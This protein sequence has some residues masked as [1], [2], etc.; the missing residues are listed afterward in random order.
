MEAARALPAVIGVLAL[1][2]MW[3]LGRE[4][5]GERAALVATLLLAVS[6]IHVWYSQEVRAY[7]LVFLLVIVTLWRYAVARRTEHM[8]GPMSRY[9]SERWTLRAVSRAETVES[10]QQSNLHPRK[11]CLERSS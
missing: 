9:L 1:P 7:G 4:V 11:A 5:A 6:P 8:A 10:P 3:L 2:F